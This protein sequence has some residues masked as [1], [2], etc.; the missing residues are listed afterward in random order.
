MSPTTP[1]AI[2]I[3]MANSLTNQ[4]ALNDAYAQLDANTLLCI[5]TLLACHYIASHPDEQQYA[6]RT[7]EGA[8]ASFQGQFTVALKSTKYGQ[9]AMMLDVTNY[10]ARHSKEVEDGYRRVAGIASLAGHQWPASVN[11]L[12]EGPED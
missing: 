7:T 1:T 10:L 2:F 3:L 11:E 6:S 8:S 5:E 9:D 4:V 12:D